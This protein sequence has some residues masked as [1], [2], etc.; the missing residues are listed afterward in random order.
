M[1]CSQESTVG[2]RGKVI[3]QSECKLNFYKFHFFAITTRNI[4]FFVYY[5]Y[6]TS[7]VTPLEHKY[8]W[9]FKKGKRLK[10]ESNGNKRHVILFVYY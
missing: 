5:N 1:K 8:Q 7:I 6:K 4:L 3:N 10:T 9:R 2:V